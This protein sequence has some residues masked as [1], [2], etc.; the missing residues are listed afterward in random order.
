[1]PLVYQQNIN[2][3]AKIAVWHIT[4]PESFFLKE[5]AIVNEI[6]NSFKRLQHLAGRYLL[7]QLEASISINE[8]LLSISIKPYLP[9]NSFHFSITHS[10]SYAAVIISNKKAVG[11]DLELP[12]QKINSIKHKFVSAAESAILNVLLLEDFHQHTLAW[13]IKEAVFKWYGQ[14]QVDFIKHICIESITEFENHFHADVV[15]KKSTDILLKAHAIF[16]E[17]YYMVWVFNEAK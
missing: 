1:M 5:V 12:Q 13:C 16:F 7:K 2:D 8:I 10:G 11:I 14:G 3:Y 6:S 9:G 17:G 15:F 4:E